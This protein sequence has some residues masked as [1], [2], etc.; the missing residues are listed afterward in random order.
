MNP[1][2]EALLAKHMRH[3]HPTAVQLYAKSSTAQA[4]SA[5][6]HPSHSIAKMTLLDAISAGS[7]EKMISREPITTTSENVCPAAKMAATGWCNPA[8]PP[9]NLPLQ[10]P[11]H[12]Q[13]QHQ[14]PPETQ[15]PQQPPHH[16][17]PLPQGQPP[18]QVSDVANRN[19]E[20]QSRPL[21]TCP[22]TSGTVVNKLPDSTTTPVSLL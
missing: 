17:Q 14:R 7:P 11:L 3:C 15:R 1:Y 6:A 5:T 10:P 19:E 4:M 9:L 2:C 21:W 16:P 12:P 13:V 20:S 18:Q 8:K 22:L